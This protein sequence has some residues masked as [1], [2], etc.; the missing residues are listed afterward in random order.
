MNRR[1]FLKLGSLFTAGV[2][3]APEVIAKALASG[4]VHAEVFID[5]RA[6]GFIG[7]RQLDQLGRT[8]LWLNQ[9]GYL[10]PDD[11]TE[12]R[13]RVMLDLPPRELAHG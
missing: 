4:P 10:A 7:G 11:P 2:M 9:Y 5:D 3:V 12:E 1:D 13:L 6:I 8:L